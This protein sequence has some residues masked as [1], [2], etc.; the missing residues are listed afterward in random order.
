MALTSVG[1]ALAASNRNS[2]VEVRAA[3]K[4]L[5]GLKQAV[6]SGAAANT[7]IAITGI[8][9]ADKLVGVIEVPAATT[10]LVDRTSVAS[11]TS[12]GNIQLTQS[13]S[14]NQLLVTYFDVA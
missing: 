8:S 10:T 4:E 1:T 12:A 2:Q 7:N 5:Q 13:T 9:T 6:V 11:I 14:G 3:V